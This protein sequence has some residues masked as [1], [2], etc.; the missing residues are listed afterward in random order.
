MFYRHAADIQGKE[1]ELPAKTN[2]S[3]KLLAFAHSNRRSLPS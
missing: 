2:A 1:K 3:I